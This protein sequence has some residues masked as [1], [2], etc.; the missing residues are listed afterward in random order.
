MIQANGHNTEQSNNDQFSSEKVKCPYLIKYSNRNDDDQKHTAIPYFIPA[1]KPLGSMVDKDR[2]YIPECSCCNIKIGLEDSRFHITHVKTS[3]VQKACFENANHLIRPNSCLCV[4]CYQAIKKRTSTKN[5]TKRACIIM[6]CEQVACHIFNSKLIDILKS[7]ILI[8]K[9]HF[10]VQTNEEKKLHKTSFCNAHYDQLLLI[11][12]CQLCGNRSLQKFK[13]HKDI[14]HEYQLILDE[15]NIPATIQFG[16]LICKPCHIYILLRRDKTTI[17]PSELQKHCDATKT[18]IIN[19]NKLKMKEL[20]S[21]KLAK[22]DINMEKK[23]EENQLLMVTSLPKNISNAFTDYS[24]IPSKSVTKGTALDAIAIPPLLVNSTPV[25][26]SMQSLTA[27]IMTT[28]ETALATEEAHLTK[29]TKPILETPITAGLTKATEDVK[30]TVAT[31]K[32]TVLMFKR[33]RQRT[34]IDEHSSVPRTKKR[35]VN[36]LTV[37]TDC[38]KHTMSELKPTI[39]VHKPTISGIKPTTPINKPTI[40]IHKPSVKVVKTSNSVDK[41]IT[42]VN[43]SMT[44]VDNPTTPVDKPTIPVHKPLN[45]KSLIFS[46]VLRPIFSSKW[47]VPKKHKKTPESISPIRKPTKLQQTNQSHQNTLESQSTSPRTE[48]SELSHQRPGPSILSSTTSDLFENLNVP[49][50]K[51]TITDHKCLDNKSPISSPLLSTLSSSKCTALKKYRKTPKSVLPIKKPTQLQT[52]QLHQNTLDSQST[53]PRTEFPE[54]RCQRAGPTT[55]SSTT[56]DMNQVFE[57]IKVPIDKPPTITNYTPLD[58]KLPVGPPVLSPFF[59]SKCTE[60]KKNGKTPESISPIIEPTQ[61]QTNQ[62]HQNTLDSQSTSSRTEFPELSRQRAGPT[63]LSSTKPNM[64]KLFEK[65]KSPYPNG[66]A[67]INHLLNLETFRNLGTLTVEKNK[68]TYCQRT[69]NTATIPPHSIHCLPAQEEY[70]TISCTDDDDNDLTNCDY[71]SEKCVPS[72]ENSSDSHFIPVKKTY[73]SC[74]IPKQKSNLPKSF[75]NKPSQYYDNDDSKIQVIDLQE[76][77][78]ITYYPN[79]TIASTTSTITMSITTTEAST[80]IVSATSSVFT[81]ISG[82]IIASEVPATVEMAA[83]ATNTSALTTAVADSTTSITDSTTDINNTEVPV[84]TDTVT[85][86]YDKSEI[87]ST[88][89]E[90]TTVTD[91]AARKESATLYNTT[92][93]TMITNVASTTTNAA[94]SATI[95]A[96]SFTSVTTTV[97]DDTTS[98]EINTE[99]STITNAITTESPNSAKSADAF[100]IINASPVT[101]DITTTTETVVETTIAA[102]KIS[103][104]SEVTSNKNTVATVPP[105]QCVS[106]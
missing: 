14:V 77:S 69:S 100:T 62:S 57:N 10:R 105:I 38:I 8:N 95:D 74:N 13:L 67:F 88:V 43:E 87:T 1:S 61:L 90:N 86:N 29:I 45:N 73:K 5:Y 71:L 99:S 49:V 46:P 11:T 55:L 106:T 51:S 42:Q 40:Q 12:Q 17:I 89:N 50:D 80:N 96:D 19:N 23:K 54:L 93:L 36:R 31:G 16:T 92:A 52:N 32:P 65:L 98:V 102:S 60:L 27:V 26:A 34:F 97:N 83:V 66:M 30:L 15:D 68:T 39:P 70:Q 84:I 22:Y 76:N 44:P 103:Y 41:P 18:R 81:T 63:T 2:S 104:D 59:S 53:S 91:A 35:I 6:A 20:E 58:N 85:I 72:D 47:P 56:S 64:I 48:F 33:K 78:S 21:I 24:S 25:A 101:S 94:V 37:T 82:A 7:T 75:D 9:I 28:I 79:I 4:G 3:D